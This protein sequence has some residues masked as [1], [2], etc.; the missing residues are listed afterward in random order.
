[1]EE[2]DVRSEVDEENYIPERDELEEESDNLVNVKDEIN[3]GANNEGLMNEVT[4][5]E[6]HEEDFIS[7]Q[8]KGEGFNFPETEIETGHWT[9]FKADVA[10]QVGRF[11]DQVVVGSPAAE[12][13]D[14][15]IGRSGL[16]DIIEASEKQLTE[17][18]QNQT[19][20]E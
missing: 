16:K 4:P 15:A 7:L 8:E 17:K 10:E 19:E 13:E 2:E 20:E 18:M 1:M 14:Q 9:S 6:E 12:T 3:R 5:K 11:S